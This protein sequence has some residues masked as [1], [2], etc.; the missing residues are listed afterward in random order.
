M[1]K[2]KAASRAKRGVKAEFELEW[3]TEEGE[4]R[5]ETFYCYPGRAVGANLFEFVTV[6]TGSEPMWEFYRTVMGEEFE[7]FEKF[8]RDE[9][10]G[11]DAD[12]LRGISSFLIEYDTGDPTE[13]SSS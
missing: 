5:T 3:E 7:R 11:V 10:H 2:F 13:Q 6:G 8:V 1:K 9:K 4:W 12:T